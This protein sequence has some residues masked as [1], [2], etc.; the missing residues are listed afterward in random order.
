MLERRSV[1]R[2]LRP[3]YSG[4]SFGPAPP[5]GERLWVRPLIGLILVVALISWF[6]FGLKLNTIK[7]SG[8]QFVSS[9]RISTAVNDQLNRHWWWRNSLLLDPGSLSTNLLASQPGLQSAKV[10]R[11]WPHG[12]S[13]KVSERRPSLGWQTGGQSYLV[14]KDGSIIG[15]LQSAAGL[16]VVTDSSNLP[17]KTGDKVVAPRFISFVQQIAA[18]L[19]KQ[20][21]KVTALRIP[22]T[23]S[24]LYVS[25]NR[26][27]MIKFDTTREAS[28]ELLS[29]QQVMK[30]LSG[31][32]KTPAEYIDLRVEGKA[33]YK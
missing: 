13:V 6:W 23:S 27:L 32:H 21:F 11:T 15:P 30:Q 28:D 22:E 24:E 31:A 26:N 29:L 19:P 17:V 20:G 4:R 9:E 25:T 14:D 5:P 12:L 8:N 18:G 33:Y 10:T 7:V 1:R 2:S 3:V 16:P